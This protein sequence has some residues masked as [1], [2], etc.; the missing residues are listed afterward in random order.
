MRDWSSGEP[1][2][3]SGLQEV[4]WKIRQIKIGKAASEMTE[5][6]LIIFSLVPL[7]PNILTVFGIAGSKKA[8]VNRDALPVKDVPSCT[9]LSP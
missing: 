5:G 7:H 2:H 6:F 4:D 1:A 9:C 3:D 8:D